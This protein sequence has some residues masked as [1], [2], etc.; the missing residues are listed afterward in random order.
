MMTLGIVI[1]RICYHSSMSD[2]GKI[3]LSRLVKVSRLLARD[4][5]ATLYE[6]MEAVGYRTRKGAQ[7]AIDR[8]EDFGIPVVEDGA[9]R[10]RRKV[11]RLLDPDSLLV[12][13]RRML[14]VLLDEEE[15]PAA[16]LLP[17]EPVPLVGGRGRLRRPLPV[18]A[19]RHDGCRC[20]A[21]A[22]GERELVPLH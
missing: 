8:L 10:G 18:E 20:R 21:E 4:E 15:S 12:F 1:M 3:F 11:Y 5:G 6:I 22:D 7:D 2:D 16:G 14:D 9:R 17:G 13:G 19:F